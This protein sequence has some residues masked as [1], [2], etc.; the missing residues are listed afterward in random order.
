MKDNVN[1]YI[2]M[3]DILMIR[4]NKIL[5]KIASSLSGL[6]LVYLTILITTVNG[7]SWLA[8]SL[9]WIVS[10]GFNLIELMSFL[11]L[12]LVFCLGQGYLYLKRPTGNVSTI[13][14]Q[15]LF[16]LLI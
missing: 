11:G 1:L 10:E 9:W 8:S 7:I 12:F 4:N 5:Y 14:H 15:Y 6:P 13:Y 2:G 16:S 3:A